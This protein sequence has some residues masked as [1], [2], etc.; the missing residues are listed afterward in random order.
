MLPERTGRSQVWK[1]SLQVLVVFHVHR[2]LEFVLLLL[3]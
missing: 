3:V 2:E 1:Q